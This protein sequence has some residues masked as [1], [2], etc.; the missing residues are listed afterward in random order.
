MSTDNHL[1]PAA[2]ATLRPRR[3]LF[4]VDGRDYWIYQC[5][6]WGTLIVL[7]ILSS[8]GGSWK[9]A[10]SFAY[11]KSLC[12]LVAFGMSHL[13]RGHIKRHGWLHRNKAIPFAPIVAGVAAISVVQTAVLFAFDAVFRNSSLLSVPEEIALN[14][15]VIFLLWFAVF[16]FWTLWYAMVLSRRR[17]VAFELEKLEL[18]LSMKD[19]E[20]RAL[21]AQVNPHFFFNSLNSI[22]ALI[23][24]DADG[25]AQ[26]VGQLAG[27]MRHG[28]QA[29]Q[30]DTV[31]M[32]DE[33][34]AVTAYL[35]MEKLRFD[36]RLQLSMDIEPGLDA[37]PLP[38]MVLQTLVENAIKHGVEHSIGQCQVRIAARRENGSVKITVSN[39]GKLASDSSSTRLGLANTSKRLALLFGPE[40][41]CTLTENQGW[42]MATVV[43]PGARA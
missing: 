25:A 18:E 39:E 38:P 7:S 16:S 9:S 19:A 6:G 3:S 20:L 22:R 27:M 26:A 13:W 11:A 33:L 15:G 36:E 10:L 34:A 31:P 29:G 1:A 32:R 24:Q 5:S 30:A 4:S 42:V 12:M 41:S 35:A 23:Y 43:L 28:L 14:I 17:A 37:I 21:Q 40:A 8:A 2:P